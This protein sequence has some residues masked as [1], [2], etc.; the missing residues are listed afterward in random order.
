MNPAMVDLKKSGL[1]F[2]FLF[3]SFFLLSNSF[4]R[5][6]EKLIVKICD[7]FQIG[8]IMGAKFLEKLQ[9]FSFFEFNIN[10]FYILLK[11][12]CLIGIVAGRI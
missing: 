8:V 10:I 3:L 6:F 12:Y 9:S 11:I 5:Q 7:F 2:Y 4:L 1:K